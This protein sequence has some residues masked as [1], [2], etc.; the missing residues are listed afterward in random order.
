[1]AALV[2]AGMRTHCST[3]SVDLGAGA[4]GRSRESEEEEEGV[5]E[6]LRAALSARVLALVLGAMAGDVDGDERARKGGLS[7]STKHCDGGLTCFRG[8]CCTVMTERWRLSR[9]K[10]R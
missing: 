9:A 7:T 4:E 3:L 2:L 6:G 10:M 5:G 8:R 1:M